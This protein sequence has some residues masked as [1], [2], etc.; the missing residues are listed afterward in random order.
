MM[1]VNIDVSDGLV[2]GSTGR[3]KKIQYG[4]LETKESIPIRL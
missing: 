3:L 4:T 2:N 1:T